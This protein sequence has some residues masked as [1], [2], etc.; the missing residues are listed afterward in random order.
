MNRYESLKEYIIFVV[1]FISILCV[2]SFSFFVT[3]N[4]YLKLELK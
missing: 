2:F 4:K 3:Y 1:L